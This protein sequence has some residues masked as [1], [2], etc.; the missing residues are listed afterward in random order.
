MKD[1]TIN[2]SSVG[3]P[4]QFVS[5]SEK[6]TKEFGLQIGQA[7]QYE[8]FRKDSSGS[9]YY[10][11]WRDFNRLRLY[12]RGE[13]SIAK[14]KNELAVDGDLS[15]LNLDWTP[16]PILPK[17][18][19]V[20]VNGMQDRLF[21]V[22]AYAQDALSQAKR[23]KYQNMVEGQMAAKDILSTVQKNT[24]FDPFIM[25]PD[26]LPA[27]DEELSLYMNLNYKPAIEIAEEEAI[28][29][30]FSENHYQDIRK[31]ID[32]DQMVIGVGMAKH[33]FLPGSGVEISYVDPAN[34][35]YS[36]TEDHYFKDCFYWGEIK[37]VSLGELIKIDP[38]L[39][40]ED[41]EKI[42]QYSQSWFDYFNTAQYYENDIFY[43]D[44]CTLMYF[45]YKTT[46]KMVYKK[47]IND[48]GG[49]RMIEKDDT[50]NPPEE[51]LEEGNFEKIEK[52]I[53]V[54]YD[55]VMVMG[56]NI[57][58]KWE[59][60][61]NM[62]RPKSS[63]QHAMPNYVAS[64]PRMYKGVIESLVRRMIP[65][66]DLIQMT[67]LKLQQVIARV[68]PDGVYIDADGLNE[69][70]LGTGAAYNPE[71]ALRLYF[72]TGS[73]IGRSYTQEGEYNQ[74]RVPI[75]QLTSNSGAS[76]TQML[77]S[78]YNHY[79]DMIRSVTGLN[80]ARD[81]STPNSDALVGVQKLAA[82]SSNTATRHILDGS[83]YIY[84]TLAEALTYR[85]ADI[86]EYSDFK[87]DFINKIGKYNV[88]ILGEISDLYIYDFGVFIELSPD[89]EQKAMLEQ[90]IQMALSKGDINLEDA[91]DIREIKNLK[92]ANQLLK[93]KRKSKQEQD[94]K[95]EMQKQS[96]MAQQQLKSQEMAAQVA[97]QTIQL[98][99]QGKLE[100]KQGE[101]QLEIERNKAEAQLKS[102]L[103]QQE[104]NYNLQLRGMDGMALSQR[105]ESRD[106]GKSERISQQNTEQ[107]KLITQ[108]K[109]NLPPQNFESNEDSL[110][111]FDLAEFEPR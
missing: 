101:V 20:V 59:L 15:Y 70:D 80:E 6:A 107:S 65:F 103:M 93:V 86:L 110:D 2:I 27:T 58:L 23:S 94:E 66:A 52:T 71:D 109:N 50:F 4:S 72:Q 99:T 45:N 111:G 82:L 95:R 44:T 42:S 60:A 53:D 97:M 69:V 76:K 34:V 100:Y 48:G 57:I 31:R 77:I 18:V 16:V 74:G 85:V 68:V 105:E 35:V 67:H 36:Y 17:F 13:Q 56:T 32:Y 90:N 81:G 55:G 37:T 108:R 39:D 83:L 91:I 64:A 10:S 102:Q 11:Q 54:W 63:S 88:S 8:W 106:K 43:R 96:M 24:G 51:M 21:K 3:F 1:V 73:V 47:K 5:D 30:M 40:N 19:D 61:K 14:Y 89:E 46:K 25:N 98:E 12:A 26:E 41:L 49:T 29:T 28:D 78:N 22:K 9:R 84:R 79:L 75:Q 38:D 62:V 33:E 7:I 87:E 104:F 92:L